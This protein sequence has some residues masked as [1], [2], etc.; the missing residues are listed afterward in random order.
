MTRLTR[1]QAVKIFIKEGNS[2]PANWISSA[3]LLIM[4]STT[5]FDAALIL[6]TDDEDEL[7]E[8]LD[9]SE[10]IG[11]GKKF[12]V[13][14]PPPLV[15]YC[16]K[17][18]RVPREIEARFIPSDSLTVEEM[19]SKKLP[20]AAHDFIHVTASSCFRLEPPNQD[21]DTLDTLRIPSRTFLESLQKALDQAILNNAKSVEHPLYQQSRFPLWT[22]GLWQRLYAA[23]ERQAEWRA[24]L[25]WLDNAACNSSPSEQTALDKAR[26]QLLQLRWNEAV[27]ISGAP[28]HARTPLLAR[29]LSWKYMTSGLM[30]IMFQA[31]SDRAEADELLDSLVIIETTRIQ[32][33]L[34][35]VVSAKDFQSDTIP[36]VLLC[37]EDT[38]KQYCSGS[39]ALVF[40]IHNRDQEHW[41]T[42]K[43]DFGEGTIAFGDSLAHRGMKPPP[44]T[45]KKLKSWLRHRFSDITTF[46]DLGDDMEH[47][48]QLDA[49]ECGL[50]AVNTA[51]H[52]VFNDDLWSPV[53]KLGYRVDWFLK[54]SSLHMSEVNMNPNA[55][56][57]TRSQRR[58][59]LSAILNSSDV[60]PSAVSSMQSDLPPSEDDPTHSPHSEHPVARF[61]SPEF[62]SSFDFAA[63]DVVTV[64]NSAGVSTG[65]MSHSISF[66]RTPTDGEPAVAITPAGLEIASV[67]S[68]ATPTEKN[69]EPGVLSPP[70]ATNW[71]TEHTKV[72]LSNLSQFEGPLP[73][74]SKKRVM[75]EAEIE[76]QL[77]AETG[78]P[79][80]KARL[81]GSSKTAIWERHQ[82]EQFRAGTLQPDPLRMENF[83]NRVH[84]V[85]ANSEVVG[86]KAIRHFKCGKTVSAGAPY[87][88]SV[89]AQHVKTCDGPPKST[90]LSSAGVAVTID[91]FFAK[92]SSDAGTSK[93][94]SIS[95]KRPV[96]PCVGL[97]AT[98][99]PSV[100]Q[101]LERT[102]TRG[103]GGLS[104]K[105]LSLSMF[106]KPFKKLSG[107]RRRRVRL[108]QRQTW[109]WRCEHDLDTIFST[110]CSGTVSS[111]SST[112]HSCLSI[113]KKKKFKNAAGI[114]VLEDWKRKFVAKVHRQVKMEALYLKVRGLKGLFDQLEENRSSPILQYVDHV[115]SK[116]QRTGGG[117]LFLG[118]LEGMALKKKRMDDGKGM[119]NFQHAPNVREFAHIIAMHSPAA[120]KFLEEVLPLP[121][122]RT[123]GKDRAKEPRLPLTINERTFTRLAEHLELLSYSGPVALA[124]DD[125]KLLPAFRPYY[126]KDTDTFYILGNAGEPFQLLDPAKFKETV[127]EAG[128]KKATK[129]SLH[130]Y[131][132]KNPLIDFPSLCY[133]LRLWTAQVPIPKVPPIVVAALAIADDMTAED[134]FPYL[135]NIISGC[136]SKGIRI[137]TYAA[138]G[139]TVERAIQHLLERK[140][141]RTLDISIPHPDGVSDPIILPLHF[142]GTQPIANIQDANHFAKT[143]RNNVYSS[144]RLLTLPNG[145][146]MYAD[147]HD[148]A[149][150]D[151]SP[152]Y[153]RDVIRPD[154]Q[155]DGAATRFLSAAVLLWLLL[156]AKHLQGLI[157][158]LFVCGEVVDAYQNRKLKHS[159]RIRMLLRGYFFFEMWAKFL[160]KAGYSKAKHFVSP[161]FVDILRILVFGFIQTVIIYRDY[162]G[163]KLIPLLP[164][165]LCTEVIEHVF[166][167]C[168]KL[169]KDFTFLEFFYMV[170]K[171]ILKLRQAMFS[172]HQSDGKQRASGYDFRY[173]DTRDINLVILALFPDNE[174][175]ELLFKLAYADAEA[176][177]ALLGI[178]PTQ[179]NST[180]PYLP[181]IGSWHK[182]PLPAAAADTVMDSTSID[183][184]WAGDSDGSFGS[185]DSGSEDE[186]DVDDPSQSPRVLRHLERRWQQVIDD[187]EDTTT[188]LS[189]EKRR[190]DLTFG[191]IGLSIEQQ[192]SI[193]ALPEQDEDGYLD[194]TAD[195]AAHIAH[196]LA[197]SLPAPNHPDSNIHP[198]QTASSTD[199]LQIDLDQLVQI[200]RDHQTRQAETGVRTAKTKQV[201]S[202]LAT[203]RIAILKEMSEIMKEDEERGVGTGLERAARWQTTTGNA[204][205]AATVAKATASKALKQRMQATTKGQLPPYV[206]NGRV[207]SISPLR[208]RLPA[209]GQGTG[210]GWG[211]IIH[212]A[213]IKL[214]KVLAVNSKSGGK[215]GKHGFIEQTDNIAAVS[216]M[217]VQVYEHF[218]GSQFL[219]RPQDQTM[220]ISRYA[221]ITS[222]AFLCLLSEAPSA[223][224][225]GLKLSSRDYADF[226]VLKGK[227]DHIVSVMQTLDKKK[228]G[229]DDPNNEDDD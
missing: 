64:P 70:A 85:D 156:Y 168:R 82:N 16:S 115:L 96:L 6:D 218:F 144:A 89:Y 108:A 20:E 141:T 211:F 161:Q 131:Y 185:D 210:S 177:F 68:V 126:D 229:G 151:D 18:C 155:D 117:E 100:A 49:T 42:C 39:V 33:Y 132:P 205:N 26:K 116:K 152:L 162:G 46:K 215:H 92:P 214:A 127:R 91:K 114:E 213:K 76:E 8:E 191:L 47:G 48:E 43:V 113:L 94:G 137:A 98:E 136:L 62:S 134:L 150:S 69:I 5:L 7:V 199:C 143:S 93:T 176:L 4:A 192:M 83:R 201:L 30:D 13:N 226:T 32:E 142:Y 74:R 209:D 102:M 172:D 193:Q 160:K 34:G 217:S 220:H 1:A 182:A 128:L 35:K 139:S 186:S 63:T 12:P 11:Q 123:I 60:T 106:G 58:L 105:V 14:P 53:S 169:V 140:A 163:D 124:C 29:F 178:S 67:S 173:M 104:L 15:V 174:E 181:P 19:L 50:V 45:V 31:L 149:M 112:C 175:L 9:T 153:K 2:H 207:S 222:A 41:L 216:Y 225:G 86:P 179:L 122:V 55:V 36:S 125:T 71:L 110:N 187:T 194:A 59:S 228:K 10:W 111:S 167:I 77:H 146:V 129:V 109:M 88:V 227:E 208:R 28:S 121:H 79:V 180:A 52:E 81:P 120:Y 157:V 184:E 95:S 65:T 37:L 84:C 166:G 56:P 101:L 202:P 223:V 57:Y 195:D 78:G 148:M 204:A 97:R 3:I 221:H 135:W 103:G 197:V 159:E 158:Y 212:G 25:K 38:I 72:A 22:V 164:W 138:D 99:I 44:E 224:H 119:Q 200:R 24:S 154:K 75:E 80:K 118:L 40:P 107:A 145:V 190:M 66:P 133:Q 183:E 51:A 206:Q 17:I 219:E 21:V 87:K 54:L 165:L 189:S 61:G 188:S 203:Q 130:D 170:A 198:L 196:V 147:I 171:L 23:G 27:N 90:K 73:F